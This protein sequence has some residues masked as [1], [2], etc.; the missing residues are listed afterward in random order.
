MPVRYVTIGA[1]YPPAT[2]LFGRNK[3]RVCFAVYNPPGRDPFLLF[4]SEAQS[5]GSTSINYIGPF[6]SGEV[7]FFSALEGHDV[8]KPWYCASNVGADYVLVYEEFLPPDVMEV[9]KEKGITSTQGLPLLM[10]GLLALG[11]VKT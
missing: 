9:L 1:S 7:V 4:D 5:G 6:P 11:G 3:A 8:T 2:Q 10:L